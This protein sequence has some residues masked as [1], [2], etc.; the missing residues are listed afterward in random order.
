MKNKKL[1]SMHKLEE[2]LDCE[3]ALKEHLSNL[4]DNAWGSQIDM[5]ID[6]ARDKV[7]ADHLALAKLYLAIKKSSDEIKARKSSFTLEC[8]GSKM[9]AL[10]EEDWSAITKIVE[11]MPEQ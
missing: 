4:S 6:D 9:I 2:V 1:A 10:R 8:A 7:K 3:K 11:A 5:A